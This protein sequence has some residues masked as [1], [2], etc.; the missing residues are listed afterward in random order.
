[1]ITRHGFRSIKL[2]GGT[3]PPTIE[4]ASI[5]ALAEAFPGY[6][7]RIDPNGA[8]SMET[9]IS[10]AAR[11]GHLIEYYEDPVDGLDAM[12]ELHRQTGLP[13][14]TNMVV[15]CFDHVRQSVAKNAVQIVLSDHH[16]WVA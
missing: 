3:L 15:T 13:L 2:K 1:M 5:E 6:P 7:L 12:A 4:V 10:V 8:W 16:Y 11:L 14:A 9:A